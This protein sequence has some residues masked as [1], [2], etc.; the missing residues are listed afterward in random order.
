MTTPGPDP[1]SALL[2]EDDPGPFAVL[3]RHGGEQV[4]I[5]RGEVGTAARLADLPLPA[6]APDEPGRP[7]LLALVPFR[8]IRERGFACRDDGVP[9][10]HLRVR[11]YQRMSLAAAVAALP[12]D[13][14][15]PR[16]AGFDIDDGAYAAAARRVVAEEIGR[17][18]GSNFVLRRTFTARLDGH[19]PRLALT[20]LRRLLLAEPG[21]YWTFAVH[22]GART[23]VGATPEA[24]VRVDGGEVRMNP[25]S[26]TYRYPPTGPD[27]AGLLAFLADAKEVNELF[28]VVDEELKMMAGVASAGGRVIGPR[29]RVMSH[30]AHTEY[31]LAGP[32]CRDVREVLAETMFAPTVTG[33]P[34]ESACAVIE[35]HEPTGRRYYGGVLALLGRDATGAGTLDAPILIRAAEISPDGLLRLPVGATLVRDSVGEHEVAETRAKAAGVLAALGLTAAGTPRTDAD[36]GPDAAAAMRALAAD[37]ATRATLAARNQRLARFWLDERDPLAGPLAPELAGRR[38]LVVDG[39]DTF[40]AM[41]AHQLRALG[42]RVS[43]CRHDQLPASRD[44]ELLVVGPGPGDPRERGAGKMATLRRLAADQLAS[45]RPLL[46]ICLGHQILADL[47]GL[48]LRRKPIPYQGLRREIDFFGRPETVGFYSTFTAVS[49]RDEVAAPGGGMVAV[50]RDR[51]SGE[52]HALRGPGLASVQF[53]CESVLTEHGVQLLRE[54]IGPLLAGAAATPSLTTAPPPPR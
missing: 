16:D 7:D 20:L 44:D 50:C 24:H 29:L 13:P 27:R 23:L 48:P 5:I 34:L 19:P 47:L 39:E 46:A 1:V 11:S 40:T 8:Q 53:H 6:G 2:A 35:R 14:I 15:A 54:L 51:A 3:R 30:L 26:G 18:A 12:T 17:G 9:L 42:L 36:A 28:M 25:I 33:S 41:L 49:D 52:V 43:V 38:T 31:E 22:T 10:E 45:G 4:E 32:V 37:P 21:A